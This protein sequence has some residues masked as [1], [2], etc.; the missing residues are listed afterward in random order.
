MIL[1]PRDF[2]PGFSFPWEREG[3]HYIGTFPSNFM[4]NEV[5]L[6]LIAEKLHQAG[7]QN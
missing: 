6:N 1:T 3:M 4:I 2:P 5:C 7:L